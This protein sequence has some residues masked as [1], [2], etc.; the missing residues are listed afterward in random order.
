MPFLNACRFVAVSGGTGDFV[1][2]GPAGAYRTPAVA[3]AINGATYGY[4]A[5][6][7]TGSEWEFGIATYDT[8]TTT[9]I[10]TT[11][12]GNHLGTTA[13][14]A[15]TLAPVVGLLPIAEQFFAK[16][17][18]IA[19]L[20][21]IDTTV[22]T[23]LELTLA[24]RAGKFFWRSGNYSTHI[25]T[26][27]NEG[28]YIKANAI[29]SS[30]G[31]WVRF[32]DFQT[33]WTKWFGTIADHTTDN[34][35]I[36]NT[37]IATTNLTNT[38]STPGK[39]SAATIEIEGGVRFASTSL[40]FLPSANWIFVYLSYFANSDTTK[41]VATGAGGTNER[42]QLSVNSGY[43]G[44][45]TGGMVGQ[46]DYNA[47]LHPGI[48]INVVK[49][50]SGADAH[51][52]TSQVRQPTS[53]NPARA[54][55]TLA[56][57]GLDRWRTV[58]EGFGGPD[59]GGLP[60]HVRLHSFLYSLSLAN[61]GTSGWGAMPANGTIIRGVTSGAKMYKTGASALSLQ[62]I[63]ITGNF[64]PGEQVTDGVT[65]ST[66]SIS[67]G[68]VQPVLSTNP[69]LAFGINA[70]T[71]GAGI[72]PNDLLT[73]FGVGGRLTIARTNAATA[74]NHIE[75][76]ANAAI[77]FTNTN[78]NG[79]LPTTG[80]QIVL[81]NNGRLIVANGVAASTTPRGYPSAV[82]ASGRFTHAGLTPM[83][84]SLN[85]ASVTNPSTGRYDVTLSNALAN[86]NYGVHVTGQGAQIPTYDL[87]S[88]TGFSIFNFNLA[89]SLANLTVEATFTIIG[90]DA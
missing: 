68:G 50:I 71:I 84:G 13:K 67:G 61:V 6:S 42:V 27:T 29:A 85:F 86:S 60:T 57:E 16:V 46:W 30:A 25:A 14:V 32:F 80:K 54:S 53:S 58:Y 76:V 28:V 19:E 40:S 22:T 72:W 10:R 75:N 33:Y 56:D 47:P 7:T 43:P 39:Q 4:R 90:G 24:G 62:G 44:D 35:T 70:P 34:S 9:A 64:V 5:E 82:T 36:I 59:T 18:S 23:A 52:G 55:L 78:T 89:G 20:K 63:W 65:T 15:F 87:R 2:A 79:T 17:S 77:L 1:V 49:H 41:G 83:T 21:A 73:A 88:T 51:F 74:S 26:D 31:A 69:F 37:I 38:L 45:A 66:N 12:L 3:G 11:V 81:D 48:F 8:A